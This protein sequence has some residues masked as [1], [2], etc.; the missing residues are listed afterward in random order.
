MTIDAELAFA[1]AADGESHVSANGE[2]GLDHGG[3]RARHLVVTLDPLQVSLGRIAMKSLPV[4]GTITGT[5][6]LDGSTNETVTAS[7]DLEH[8]ENDAYTHLVATGDVDFARDSSTA[9]HAEATR[10]R[11]PPG[12]AP[13]M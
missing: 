5:A 7:A 1:N 12:S 6:T 8:R 4:G 11:Q 3:Y 9:G 13:L 2:I 10:R